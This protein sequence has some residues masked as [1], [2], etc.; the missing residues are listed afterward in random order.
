[1]THAEIVHSHSAA[2][3]EIPRAAGHSFPVI[4]RDQ[5]PASIVFR[6]LVKSVDR[7]LLSLERAVLEINAAAQFLHFSHEHLVSS[8]IAVDIAKERGDSNGRGEQ[9]EPLVE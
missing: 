3:L 6:S 5:M 4:H 1:M 2:M 7:E 8:G 9:H